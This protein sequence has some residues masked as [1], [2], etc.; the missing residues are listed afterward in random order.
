MFSENYQVSQDAKIL[1]V[2]VGGAGGNALNTMIRRGIGNVTHLAIN[3][4]SQALASSESENTLNIGMEATRGYGAGTNP[5]VGYNSA[6]ESAESIRQALEG[7]DM[8]FI[9]AGMGGGTGT[10]A[11]PVVA[12]IAKSMGILTVAVVTKPFTFE[13]AKRMAAAK[14]GIA[15][16]KKHVDSLIV[17]DNQ[18]LLKALPKNTSLP[19]AFSQADGVLAGAVDAISKVITSTGLVNVD[20]AD[21]RTVMESNGRALMGVG[22]GQGEDRALVAAEAAIHS[23]LLEDFEITAAKGILCTITHGP[24]FGIDELATVGE[25]IHQ[26]AAPDANI[27]LGTI[28]DY[29]IESRCV[30]TVIATGIGSTDDMVSVESHATTQAATANVNNVSAPSAATTHVPQ[31]NAP[32]AVKA[33]QSTIDQITPNAEVSISA[34]VSDRVVSSDKPWLSRPSF[35]GK[36]NS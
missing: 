18:K 4:D 31:N 16:L 26:L 14:I 34:D 13:G 24:D 12:E 1:I 36:G 15:S 27:V 19:D 9:A 10:G 11:S 30:V 6:I 2:G 20:F 5:Q 17:I 33:V 29:N 23:P 3:T 21:V 32:Q 22:E 8:L 35:L 28:P 25:R 7:V